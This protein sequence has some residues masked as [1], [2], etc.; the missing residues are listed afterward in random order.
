ML[1]GCSVITPH[2]CQLYDAV[3]RQ[4]ACVLRLCCDVCATAICGNTMILCS[5]WS[6]CQARVCMHAQTAV[7]S[8][9]HCYACSHSMYAN[10]V[11]PCMSSQH[12]VVGCCIH[13][14]IPGLKLSGFL[15]AWV[16]LAAFVSSSQCYVCSGW[17]AAASVSAKRLHDDL[18]PSDG[19][20]QHGHV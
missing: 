8:S 5:S 13:N 7:L 10:L 14:T 11:M 17:R 12:S 2:C 9:L 1:F 3:Y 19:P 20:G 18:L 4:P 6:L 16:F 15:I